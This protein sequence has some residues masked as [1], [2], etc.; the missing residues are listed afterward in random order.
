MVGFFYHPEMR[1]IIRVFSL[2]TR[3]VIYLK[4]TGQIPQKCFHTH[5]LTAP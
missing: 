4:A 3:L 5:V 2:T 1:N